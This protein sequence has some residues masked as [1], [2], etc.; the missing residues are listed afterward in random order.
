MAL[1][2]Q[3]LIDTEFASPPEVHF[4]LEE[5][6]KSED[7]T[8]NDISHVIESDPTLAA[9][10]LKIVNSP[11]YGLMGQVDSI[12][13]AV[14]IIGKESLAELAL[15]AAAMEKFDDIPNDVFDLK[16]F[17]CH[18]IACAFAAQRVAKYRDYPR[19]EQLYLAGILHDIGQ[20]VLLQ[21]EPEIYFDVCLKSKN[22]SDQGLI[23][24]E[25]EE[26]GYD[27]AQIGG[28]LLKEWRLPASIYVPVMN[29]H[30]PLK[31]QT[32]K[33]ESFILHIAE[34]IAY[35]V[36]FGKSSEPALPFLQKEAIKF[37]NLN[38][39]FIYEIR[40]QIR[41]KAGEAVNKFF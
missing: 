32:Y 35:E 29:H 16:E 12:D 38:L 8:F 4:K 17:W 25:K 9:K 37:L 18:S 41:D 10:L 7:C 26:L 19:P 3:K 15:A 23:I 1:T 14:G 28:I 39:D 34:L 27:H 31:A 33:E 13:H 36:G 21:K 24:A 30:E 2:L 22:S 20:L 5:V 11:T 40:S 6:L